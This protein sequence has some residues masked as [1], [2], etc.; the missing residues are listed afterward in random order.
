MCA[1]GFEVDYHGT[2][3]AYFMSTEEAVAGMNPELL[4]LYHAIHKNLASTYNSRFDP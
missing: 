3:A 4:H 1:A 2:R